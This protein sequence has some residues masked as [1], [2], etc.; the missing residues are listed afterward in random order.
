MHTFGKHGKRENCLL[1]Y[2]KK[3]KKKRRAEAYS[4]SCQTSEVEDF[5]K[6]VEQLHI[7]AKRSMLEVLKDFYCA[8]G[9]HNTCLLKTRAPYFSMFF[10]SRNGFKPFT[11]IAKNPILDALSGPV[12][13]KSISSFTFASSVRVQV[14]RIFRKGAKYFK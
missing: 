6:I 3:G 4:G 13:T 11:V 2:C 10:N 9:L 5:T 1:K 7:L 12:Y 14:V 8:S